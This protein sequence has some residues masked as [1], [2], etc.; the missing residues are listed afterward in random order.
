[1]PE[2]VVFGIW[3]LNTLKMVKTPVFI[4]VFV[5]EKSFKIQQ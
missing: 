3:V 2:N 5:F 1:M 4:T